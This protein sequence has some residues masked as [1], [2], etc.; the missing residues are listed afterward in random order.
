MS[1]V[2]YP[3]SEIEFATSFFSRLKGLLF[4]QPSQKSLLISPCKS[5]HTF[6]IKANL[7]IAFL[8]RQGVVLEQYQNVV[9]NTRLRH[10]KAYAVL[11]RFSS[12]ARV[13]PEKEDQIMFGFSTA[14]HLRENGEII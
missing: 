9:P 3:W 1:K 12:S 7:D 8:D 10:R 2:Y 11:E 4:A 13:W 5:I 6:G 14:I